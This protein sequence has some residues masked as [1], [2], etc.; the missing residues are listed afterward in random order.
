[1]LEANGDSQHEDSLLTHLS[2]VVHPK[3]ARLGFM[4][5]G[6]RLRLAVQSLTMFHTHASTFLAQDASVDVITSPMT[7]PVR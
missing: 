6:A 2:L 1:M 3:R 7:S 5:A 4:G